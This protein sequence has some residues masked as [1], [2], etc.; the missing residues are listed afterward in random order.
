M[1]KQGF[2]H[3]LFRV[4]YAFVFLNC[5]LL[6]QCVSFSPSV[7]SFIHFCPILSILTGCLAESSPAFIQCQGALKAFIITSIII[8][9]IIIITI[10]IHHHHHHHQHHHHHPQVDN[11]KLS[12]DDSAWIFIRHLLLLCSLFLPLIIII[13]REGVRRK[14]CF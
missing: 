9:T 3:K 8:I 11:R 1:L 14:K 12:G 13:I 4:V 6:S 5:P 2:I 10:I 7:S